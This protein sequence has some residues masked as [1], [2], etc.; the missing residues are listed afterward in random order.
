MPILLSE[1]RL[2]IEFS[3]LNRRRPIHRPT[4]VLERAPGAHQSDI[5][6]FVAKKIGQLKPGE[7][8]EEDIP[9]RVLMGVM[10]EEMYFS[11][12]LNTDWQPGEVAVD[13]IA[14]N[15]DGIGV[16]PTEWLP[17]EAFIEETKC[18]EKKLKTGVEFME[19]FMWMHQG[20]AYC[21]CYGPRVV[22]WTIWYYRGDYR[23]SGPVCM[24]Y[25]I[26][27]SDKEVEQTWAMLKKN[28]D[29]A[30]RA[31]ED[32][33]QAREKAKAAGDA[34]GWKKWLRTA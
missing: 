17:D 33:R 30:M 34:S 18:T 6:A 16:G 3:D 31:V 8:F 19:D 15:C 10:F 13:G 24:Q 11:L 7:P 22:K 28:K 29:A 26:R 12:V 20:R 27:F 21:Y 5:L 25:V 4:E 9:E 32:E 23:G 14:V 1:H 2:T